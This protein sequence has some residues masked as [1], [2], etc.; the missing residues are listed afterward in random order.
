MSHMVRPRFISYMIF[1]I[2]YFA[3]HTRGMSKSLADLLADRNFD[4]PPEMLAIK[5]FV[6]ETFDEDCE[7]LLHERDITI[8]VRSAS[9]ANALRLKVNDLRAAAQTKKRLLFRIR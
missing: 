8:S 6:K 7:V 3:C 9:L 4:E 5:Q 2:G 1:H